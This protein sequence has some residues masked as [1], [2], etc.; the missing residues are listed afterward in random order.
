VLSE[1]LGVLINP[2]G[3][4]KVDKWALAFVIVGLIS[5]VRYVSLRFRPVPQNYSLAL[6]FA[7]LSIGNLVAP[8]FL[9]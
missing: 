2:D 1:L 8:C 4:S 3:E 5:F 9:C 7:A 6:K